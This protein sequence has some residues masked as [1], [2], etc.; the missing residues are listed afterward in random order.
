MALTIKSLK[1]QQAK[2]EK[3]AEK[4]PAP[5]EVWKAKD[6]SLVKGGSPEGEWLYCPPGHPISRADL[7][8]V[9]NTDSEAETAETQEEKPVEA[10]EDKAT[11]TKEAK[12]TE[13]KAKASKK[14]SRPRSG[15]I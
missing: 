2:A 5:F 8:R 3:M 13:T 15:R 9:A 1:Q 4:V 6:G 10:K 7:E 12:E 14:K 11:E